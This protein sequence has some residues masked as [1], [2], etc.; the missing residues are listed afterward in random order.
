VI[1]LPR[2]VSEW[3]VA[4]DHGTTNPFVALL[5][6]LGRDRE[7]RQALYVAR[8]WR[9]DSKVKQGQLTDAQYSAELRRWLNDLEEQ[10]PGAST[11][12]RVIVDPSAASFIAQLYVDQWAGVRGADNT[13][14]DGIRSTASLMAAI[15]LQIHS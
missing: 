3:V 7:G 6:G 9:W 2:K 8:E 13:V 12:W 10:L 4:V 14:N 15:R 1:D 11:P 5:I